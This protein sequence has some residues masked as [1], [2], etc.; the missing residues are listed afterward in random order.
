MIALGKAA[1][2]VP[3]HVKVRFHGIRIADRW[4]RITAVLLRKGGR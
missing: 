4:Q 1:Y 2:H 3:T